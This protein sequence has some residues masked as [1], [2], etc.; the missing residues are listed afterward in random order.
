MYQSIEK[1]SFYMKHS[2]LM[3]VLDRPIGNNR[4]HSAFFPS[5]SIMSVSWCYCYVIPDLVVKSIVQRKLTRVG[6]R[7]CSGPCEVGVAMSS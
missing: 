3:H 5:L 7:I 2:M 4:N 6:K 1:K